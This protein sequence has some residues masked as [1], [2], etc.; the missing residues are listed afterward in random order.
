MTVLLLLLTSILA[1]VFL[2]PYLF[3]PLSLKLLRRRPV[4]FAS[5]AVPVS[6]TLVFCAYQEERSLPDK[7]ANLRA[8]RAVYPDLQFACYVD[9]CTDRTLEMLQAESDLIQVVAATERTGK[10]LGMRRLAEQCETDVMIFTDANVILQPESVAAMLA[11]FADPEVGGVCGTLHYTNEDES[12][13]ART[14]GAYWRLEETIKKLESASGSTMGA[15]GSIFAT[16][17][18]LYPVVP[19]YLLDDFIVSMSVIFAGYRLVSAG[20]VHAYERSATVS[21]DEFRR[22]RR[23]AARAYASHLHLWPQVKDQGPA[24]LY[25]YI[26]HRL[27]RWWGGPVLAVGL[28]SG[29]LFFLSAGWWPLAVLLVLFVATMGLVGSKFTDR[30]LAPV[31]E[32]HVALVATMLGVFDALRGRRYQ[33]WTPAQS[34]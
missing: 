21:A 27:L 11:Y 23:I 20:D 5:G 29:L 33:T 24:I 16:R 26:S 9:L 34:R 19:S 3:Y 31:Y 30:L 15:D 1:L 13:T 8:I 28:V 10:A 14:S 22:K 32:V 25:R 4:N 17:R 7:I 12:P 6:A 18:R 2:H